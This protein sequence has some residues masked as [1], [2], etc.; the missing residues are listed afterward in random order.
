MFQHQSHT[1]V[2]DFYSNNQKSSKTHQ[3]QP[4]SLYYNHNNF[5]RFIIPIIS[6]IIEARISPI[7]TTKSRNILKST[8]T[9]T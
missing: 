5:R 3:Q 4:R 6:H 1:L 9:Q 7:K 8:Y 2:H